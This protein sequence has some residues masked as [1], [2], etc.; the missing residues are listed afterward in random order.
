MDGS[1]LRT[2]QYHR[3]SRTAA[4]AEALE[5]PRYAALGLRVAL[6]QFVADYI[7]EG[8]F[9]DLPAWLI[10]RAA[11]WDGEPAVLISAMQDC[12]L[13]DADLCLLESDVDVRSSAASSLPAPEPSTV[14][15]IVRVPV[16]SPPLHSNPVILTPVRPSSAEIAQR[17]QT[18]PEMAAF[19]AEAQKLIGTFGHP[20]TA[21]LVMVHD[22]YGLSWDVLLILLHSVRELD[23]EN[24][25][26]TA[27]K[28]YESYAKKL[29]AAG[30]ATA[31]D[32]E[33]F[34][35]SYRDV[36]KLFRLLSSK[37]GLSNSKPTP[38]QREK[39]ERWTQWGF[40]A[41]LIDLAYQ[42]ALDKPAKQPFLFAD[43]I[44]TDWQ[45]NGIFTPEAVAKSRAAWAAR[46][47]FKPQAGTGTSGWRKPNQAAVYSDAPPPNH[48]LEKAG[49][50]HRRGYGIDPKAGRKKG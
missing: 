2:Q 19:F 41:E 29:Y 25:V 20:E 15:Q 17:L 39:F 23:G 50:R 46:L 33:R 32:A 10:A 6:G 11:G 18:E 34:F 21:S 22:Y 4:L 40:S 35:V 30:V 7:P 38:S 45:E 26:K 14:S 43:K 13:F 48:S 3:D 8:V 1:A 12:G 31:E 44:L 49:E 42:T 24:G 28:T 5:M 36:P 16:A 37:W 9:T 27:T 47:R